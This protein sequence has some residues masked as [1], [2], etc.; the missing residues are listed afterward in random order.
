MTGT[1]RT[2]VCG[3][4]LIVA[5]ACVGC[6]SSRPMEVTV[7]LDDRIRTA[8]GYPT[9]EVDLVGV[10][11][12]DVLRDIDPDEYFAP[13]SEWRRNAD[14]FTMAFSNEHAE[15][16]WL[17]RDERCWSAWKKAGAV[18]LLVLV[19][20]LP[21]STDSRSRRLVLPL[22]SKEWESSPLEIVIYSNQ[23]R[24]VTKRAEPDS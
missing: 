11:D 7:R 5:A 3:L 20:H 10:N 13:G 9:L 8:S 2:L 21:R 1:A 12:T 17:K 6:Q 18:D 24:C 16:K 14:N 19:D 23:V 22:D 15:P 4:L